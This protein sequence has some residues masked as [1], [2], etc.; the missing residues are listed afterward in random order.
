MDGPKGPFP[1]IVTIL[2][3]LDISSRTE[4]EFGGGAPKHD[5]A[6]FVVARR[7]SREGQQSAS[8]S[9]PRPDA[10]RL[11]NSSY[12]CSQRQFRL[13]FAGTVSISGY[14]HAGWAGVAENFQIGCGPGRYP[15]SQ[16]LLLCPI[17]WAGERIFYQL[18]GKIDMFGIDRRGFLRLASLFG[19]AVPAGAAL[20]ASPEKDGGSS[21]PMIPEDDLAFPPPMPRRPAL[22]ENPPLELP[23][24]EMESVHSNPS[25]VF[26]KRH[27]MSTREE[28][29]AAL[30]EMRK[31]YKPF[32]ADYTP[33]AP[34]TRA[35]LELD[36]FQFRMEEPEDLADIS[37]VWRGEG[38]WEN[39]GIPDYRGPLGWW[40]GY[41]RKVLDI[42]AS[43]WKQEA[44]FL[45]FSGVDYKCQVYLN[46][47]MVTT[48]EGFFGPFEVQL[49]PYLKRDAENLLVVRIQNESIMMG[50]DSWIG[51]PKEDGDKIYADCG[52]GWN[53]PVLGWHECPPGAGIWQ[54]VFL[55]GRPKVAVT[56]IFVRPHLKEKSI[57]VRLEVNHSEN[58]NRDIDLLLSIY[59]KN[60]HG[61]A[62]EN[63]PVKVAPAGPGSSEYRT[64][65]HFEN[66]RTWEPDAPYLY[67]LR[68]AIRP[69]EG[70]PLDVAQDQFGMREFRMDATSSIK[71]AL[72]LNDKP[73]ILRGANTMGNFEVSVMKGDEQQ[74]IDDILIGKIAHMNFF[75]LT[76][77]PEQPEVYAMFDRLGMM[78]QT[79]LPLFGQLRRP[80]IAEAIHQVGEMEKLVRNHPSSIIITYINEPTSAVKDHREHRDL[81]RPELTLFFHSATALVHTLNPDRVVKPVEG[82]YNPPEPG[83]PD[84]HIYCMWYPNHAEPIGKFIKGYWVDSKPGWKHTSG[85]YGIE[86]LEGA[87]T[88]Y[89][90]YPK[91]WLPAS[92]NA[93]W[94]PNAIPYTQTWAMHDAWFDTQNTLP[95]WIAASQ[96]YQA[97][98]IDVMTRAFRRQTYRIISS[99]VHLL[100]DAWPDC[101][102]KALL[103]VDRRPKPAYFKFRDGLTPLMVDVTTNRH[104]YFSGEKLQ[105]EFWVCN[106]RRAEFPRGELVWEVLQGG[107][108][109][110]AQSA[111]AEI[112][113]F[114]SAFQ[115]FFRYAAPVVTQRERLTIH[116]GLKNP[117][118]RLVHDHTFEVD[119][120]PAFDRAKNSKTEVAIVGRPEGR[121]WRLAGK[122]GIEPHT[123]STAREHARIAFVDDVDAYAMVRPALMRFAEQG[124]TAVFLEQR[125]G[126]V[127][128]L[129]KTDVKIMELGGR[130]FV[131]RKTGHPLVA[132]FEPFDFSYWYDER[133]GYIGDV[134]STFMDGEGLALILQ[135]AMTVRAGDPKAHRMVRPVA[136]E[137]RIGKG[138]IIISQ[139]EASERVTYEPVAAAYY[140]AVIN[141]AKG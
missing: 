72:Y 90:Y 12:G 111:P 29:E 53:D 23:D 119:I 121:A 107:R 65:V 129:N 57:E 11:T 122:L 132:S 109:A 46:G 41:Y 117:S 64:D 31:R 3:N 70:D 21:E 24:I 85:E 133:K 110:F 4:Y 105:I 116:L 127:W 30:T 130:Q 140:Q 7:S 136:G 8:A 1:I 84:N 82:D 39:V 34:V 6:R 20:P 2:A 55:E 17:R 63:I 15:P 88:M 101:W 59:P 32:L 97:F 74:L 98:G 60:F 69:H 100:I 135:T 25:V 40:A 102:Q 27:T 83:L 10:L 19:L 58:T 138:S 112:P 35:R 137:L 93:H 28:L 113:S 103:D 13:N 16:E 75:R 126:V 91:A 141:R 54:K 56:G 9:F 67:T 99:A 94:N 125:P 89:K 87:A 134:A 47:R 95:E 106:D 104:H 68:A 78:A 86:G 14:A 131:S 120:F 81:T 43:V 49:T 52:P 73:I 108:R 45:C 66:F 38:S 50:E 36:T 71:G 118:G 5:C 114:T 76:Q 79:D 62:L 61:L 77:S 18:T 115:G 26:P 42:P 139:L 51:G 37:R 44:V 80:K 22:V 128:H 123:F 96:A 92:P 48:H 33:P 124:G